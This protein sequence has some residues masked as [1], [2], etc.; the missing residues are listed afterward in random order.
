MT[1]FFV[2]DGGVPDSW[3]GALFYFITPLFSGNC[4]IN[5]LLITLYIDMVR[6]LGNSMERVPI[7]DLG[8]VIYYKQSKDYTDEEF[9]SSKD[10]KREINKGNLIKLSQYKS[11]R[12]ASDGNGQ[13]GGLSMNDVRQAVKEAIAQN[14]SAAQEPE[15]ESL[16]DALKGLIPSLIDTMRREISSL[17]GRMGPAAEARKYKEYV[18]PKYIP[19]VSTDGMTS[20]IKI[21]SKETSG[22]DISSNLDA[23]RNL[24]NNK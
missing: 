6:V 10:L 18:D 2:V 15:K 17:A 3:P 4:I 11:P 19:D 1:P 20:N 13:S 24:Q 14:P 23:L 12:N 22:D 16:S 5:N 9:E 8:D 21:E 7:R